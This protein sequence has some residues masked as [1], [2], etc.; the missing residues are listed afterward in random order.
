MRKRGRGFFCGFSYKIE[1][2]GCFNCYKA[3]EAL[4]G[5]ILGIAPVGECDYF[6]FDI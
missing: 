3:K 6:G 2:K 4:F 1:G 5:A